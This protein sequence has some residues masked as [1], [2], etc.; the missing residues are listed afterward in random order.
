[1]ADSREQYAVSN[2]LDL[3]DTCYRGM[4]EPVTVRSRTT[5]RLVGSGQGPDPDPTFVR[6]E[7]DA[8]PL[9][10]AFPFSSFILLVVSRGNAEGEEG[11][12]GVVVVGTATEVAAAA[13]R[14]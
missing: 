2:E 5:M 14:G 9:F 11:A 12:V 8:R 6:K 4:G 1:M 13:A 7:P 3:Y 10:L